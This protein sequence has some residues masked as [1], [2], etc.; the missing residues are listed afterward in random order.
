MIP[1]YNEKNNVEILLS[2]IK[3]LKTKC[4][5]LFIDDNSPDGTGKLLGE[6]AS[7]KE[8]FVIHRKFK[9][10]IGSAHLRAFEWAYSKKYDFL[11]TLDGDLT[12]TPD[13]IKKFILKIKNFDIIVG[14][15]FLMK[16]SLSGWSFHRKLLTYLGHYVTNI[17]LNLTFDSTCGFRIYNLNNIDKDLLSIIQSKGYSFFIESLFIFNV[18]N[19]KISEIPIIL[20]KRTYGNSKMKFS[21]II[22]SV[23]VIMEL[24]FKRVFKSRALLIKKKFDLKIKENLQKKERFEWDNYWKKKKS[25]LKFIYD[26][27]AFFYRNL[28]IKPAL[29]HFFCKH[30]N[31]KIPKTLHA[32]CG[33]GQVDVDLV[34]KAKLT[35]IDISPKALEKYKVNHDKDVEIIHGDI[36]KMPFKSNFFEIIFNLGVMEHFDENQIKNILTEFKRT[37]TKDGKLILFWPPKYGL[38]VMFLKFVKKIIFLISR[39]NITFHPHEI[40]LIK[41]KKHAENILNRSG[42]KIIESYFGIRDFFTHQI[43]VAKK[44]N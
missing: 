28:I 24:F 39:K 4:D 20:P 14:S 1:T 36:F 18:N 27:I 43:I 6:L 40:T 35:A 42:F 12:H 32:G 34:K 29:N 15:R 26:F 31:E 2:K 37:L 16:N 23:K 30:A 17:F 9:L 41:S 8:I 3:K 38:S 44:Q 25:S 22:K 33:S 13:D 10:G 19:Y 7:K 5:I 11:I 21:D